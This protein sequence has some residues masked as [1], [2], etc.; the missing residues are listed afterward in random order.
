MNV[1]VLV[2]LCGR[3]RLRPFWFVAV[4]D[5]DRKEQNDGWKGKG[6]GGPEE[7]RGRKKR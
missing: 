1:A 7:T 2:L 6:K 5:V 4:L 3:F